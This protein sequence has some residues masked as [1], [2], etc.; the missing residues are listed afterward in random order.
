MVTLDY[1]KTNC[2]S[3]KRALEQVNWQYMF[4]NKESTIKNINILIY[5]KDN[6]C[7]SNFLPNKDINIGRG[8]FRSIWTAVYQF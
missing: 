8:Y 1:D 2:N 3:I 7:F 5:I 4:E 6:E